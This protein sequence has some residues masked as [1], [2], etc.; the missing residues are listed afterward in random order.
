MVLVIALRPFDFFI[1]KILFKDKQKILYA[2]FIIA[3]YITI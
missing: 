3:F 2:K 1:L